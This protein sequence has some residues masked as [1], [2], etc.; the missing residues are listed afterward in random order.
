MRF[1]AASVWALEQFGP[2]ELGDRRLSRRLVSYAAQAAAHPSLSIPR[3]CGC[4]K[5]TKGA[6]RLF[7]N[8]ATT[9]EAVIG[10]HLALTAAAV[11]RAG[12]VLHVGDTTTLSFDHPHTEGLG[13]PGA[14]GGGQGMLVHNTL[15]V[16]VSGGIDAPPRVLG[17]AH[18]QLWARVEGRKKTPESAKWPDAVNA[19]G[20]APAAVRFVHVGDAESDCWEALAA[21]EVQSVGHVIRACQDRLVSAGTDPH[22]RPAGKLFELV[23]ARPPLGG[24]Y[25]WARARG[26]EEARLVKLLVSATPVTIR[27]PKNWADK[28]HRG[29][30]P[31]PAPLV[32]WA[33]RVWEADAPEGRTPIEWVLLTDQPVAGLQTALLVAFWYSCRWLVEEYHKCLKTG[34]KVEERQLEHV[35]RL[36][37][38]VGVLSVVAVR[39]LQL[40]HE[41]RVDPDTPAAAVVPGP[42]VKTLAAYLKISATM[43]A[44]QFW[45]GTA[46]LGGF[47][48]RKGDGDPGWQALWHGWWKLQL[49]TDGA[50]LGR[51]MRSG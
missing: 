4:W 8:D 13:P 5:Q 41:A 7:D 49:L 17:L 12:V 30:T 40:K 29:D 37:P 48:G 46:Q 15:A 1:P 6:Y 9:H 11:A 16:D 14:G 39:L 28:K 18:Q 2:A 47:L 50:E 27:P 34:C 26:N 32:R 19:I 10:P 36:E 44:R 3:Q 20:P 23:R 38:L 43:T 35:E 45:R 21:L 51:R 42:Y 24:K 22:G 33:L 31:R 25:L